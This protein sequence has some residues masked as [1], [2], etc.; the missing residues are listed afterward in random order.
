MVILR[1][2]DNIEIHRTKQTP[3]ADSLNGRSDAES[4]GRRVSGVGRSPV[5]GRDCLCVDGPGGPPV[6]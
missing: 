5:A 4:V 1:K 2:Q 6:I 3:P